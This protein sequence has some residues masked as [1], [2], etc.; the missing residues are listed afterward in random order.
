MVEKEYLVLGVLALLIVV[1]AVQALQLNELKSRVA[2]L[3]VAG[4]RAQ[5]ASAPVQSTQP[6]ALPPSLQNLPTQVGGC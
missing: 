2:A 5:A 1:M 4:V 6:V 3:S